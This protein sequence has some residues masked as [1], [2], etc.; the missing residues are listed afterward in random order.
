MQLKADQLSYLEFGLGKKEKSL[1]VMFKCYGRNKRIQTHARQLVIK[2]FK[3][4]QMKESRH[5]PSQNK[6]AFVPPIISRGGSYTEPC[7]PFQRKQQQPF[8]NHARTHTRKSAH[9]R[10]QCPTKG[11]VPTMML[12]HVAG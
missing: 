9:V 6:P 10:P 5:F 11:V 8:Q 1:T 7:R 3:E 4:S 12:Y 2:P